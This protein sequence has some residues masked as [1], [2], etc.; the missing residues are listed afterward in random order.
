MYPVVSFPPLEGMRYP[1]LLDRKLVRI[2]AAADEILAMP[3]LERAAVRVLMTSASRGCDAALVAGLPNLALVVSQGAGREKIDCDALE[4][5]GI[6]LRCVSEAVVDDVADLAMLLTHALCRRLIEAN[7]FARSGG[8]KDRRFGLGVSISGLTMGIA[9]LSGRIGQAI[10]ARAKASHMAI[11]ALD[12]PSN[13]GLG[14]SL[15][16]DWTALAEASDVLVL[17]LPATE[18]LRHAVNADVL[19][20]LGPTGWLVNVGR[21]MLVDTSALIEALQNATIAGA[22]LD[23][24]EGEP[25]VPPVLAQATNVIVTPHI[26][27]QTWGQR[28]RG[29]QIAE[30]TVLAFFDA[31]QS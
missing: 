27:A 3:E 16:P 5:R 2:V 13:R 22:G 20:A 9:G 6:R 8:W 24:L 21:G 28:A 4:A 14:A 29:A 15:H 17:A 26:G 10:A 19:T 30:D 31:S 7:S 23:V 1:G 11:A 18:S 12:R 25:D